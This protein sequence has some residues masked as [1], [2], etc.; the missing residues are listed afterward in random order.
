MLLEHCYRTSVALQGVNALSRSTISVRPCGVARADGD[1]GSASELAP[2]T[3]QAKE[4]YGENA[5]FPHSAKSIGSWA[6]G[7][8]ALVVG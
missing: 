2:V 7:V 1:R 6:L 3:V 5:S 8:R 4:S